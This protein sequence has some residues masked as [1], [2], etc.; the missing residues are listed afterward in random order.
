MGRAIVRPAARRD[1]IQNFTYLGQNSSL[2][3]A[4]RFLKASRLT[5]AELAQS[6][7]IG[8]PRKWG[9]FRDLRM[10][11]VRGFERYLIFYRPIDAGVQIERVIHAAQDYKRVLGPQ[12]P[13]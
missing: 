11:R 1:L 3:T 9:K 7:G 8:V 13:D 10:W 5:F 12:A 6:P 4:R 2:A